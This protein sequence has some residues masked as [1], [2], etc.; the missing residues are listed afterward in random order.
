MRVTTAKAG[1]ASEFN[2]SNA[3]TSKP[4][5]GESLLPLRFIRKRV[6]L[7]HK[8]RRYTRPVIALHLVDAVITS[9]GTRPHSTAAT[10]PPHHHNGIPRRATHFLETSAVLPHS[11]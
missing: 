8:Q 3:D 6:P 11:R 9:A 4:G 2:T 10:A 7:R 5:K 1:H